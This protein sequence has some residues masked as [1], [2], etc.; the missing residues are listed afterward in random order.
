MEGKA[1][2]ALGGHRCLT[3]S[4]SIDG[5]LVNLRMDRDAPTA[6]EKQGVGLEL[7]D[8]LVARVHCHRLEVR[9]KSFP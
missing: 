3:F 4:C 2:G 6:S 9:R 1:R 7:Q 8:R 5:E